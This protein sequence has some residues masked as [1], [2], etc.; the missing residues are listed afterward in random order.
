VQRILQGKTA[1]RETR[2]DFTYRRLVVCGACGY[3]LIGEL[4]KGHAYYRCHTEG[5]PTKTIR[6]EAI[7][8]SL[9]QT[10]GSLRLDDAEIER[11]GAWIQDAHMEQDAVRE[12]EARNVKLLLDQNQARR[13]RLMDAFL[14]GTVE[15]ELFEERKA[16]L[17]LE[18]TGL[19]EELAHL[20]RRDGN[21]LV[22]LGKFLELAKT[23]SLLYK[24]ALSHE[25][26]DFVKRLT[27][28]LSAVG[29]N[30][31]VALTIPAQVIAN[32][33]KTSSCALERGVPRT[34]PKPRTLERTLEKLLEHFAQEPVP[35]AV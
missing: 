30:V 5:C 13:A 6:E 2:H 34:E 18:S 31:S 12:Q 9:R 16:G 29:K 25:K 11:A 8:D 15:K 22:R 14:D 20:E 33:T 24:E 19:K 28:N 32:R 4:Q 1:G 3:S 7:E 10:F 21:A 35:E 27:S 26:R 17:L 23:A